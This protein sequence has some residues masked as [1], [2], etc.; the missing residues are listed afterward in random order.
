V[1][2]MD[3]GGPAFPCKKWERE[4]GCE[5]IVAHREVTYTGLSLRDYFAGQA[6]AG[7]FTAVTA[8]DDPP[9]V[10][11]LCYRFADAMLKERA[12]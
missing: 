1:S 4:P 8:D 5:A 9:A 2:L 11:A 12:E 10:A 6:L 7:L 3:A